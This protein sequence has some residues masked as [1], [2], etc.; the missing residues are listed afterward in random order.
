MGGK[1]LCAPKHYHS[2]DD[3]AHSTCGLTS[4]CPRALWGPPILRY[5]RETTQKGTKKPP[6][7]RNEHQHPETKTGS[8]LGLRGSKPDSEGT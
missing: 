6:N 3:M 8:Y 4:P 7:L 2:P 1:L 5:V